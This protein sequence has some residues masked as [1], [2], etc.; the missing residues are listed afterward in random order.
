MAWNVT[1]E[2]MG[3]KYVCFKLHRVGLLWIGLIAACVSQIGCL[4][5]GAGIMSGLKTLA[6]GT[7]AII[8]IA[9]VG[10]FGFSVRDLLAGKKDSFA[11][12]SSKWVWRKFFN[13]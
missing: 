4:P 13:D 7:K 5:S 11:L 6:F 12:R 8:G 10:L 1:T 9:M 2:S 3:Y